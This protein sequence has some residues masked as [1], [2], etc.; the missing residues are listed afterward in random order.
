MTNGE[1]QRPDEQGQP[2]YVRVDTGHQG[3]RP[4]A[5]DVYHINAVD[6]VTQ[7]RIV[8]ATSRISEAG[9]EPLL[10]SLPR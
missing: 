9:L 3:D 8:A 5:K 7:W 2:G 1:R 10:A 4:G 6:E